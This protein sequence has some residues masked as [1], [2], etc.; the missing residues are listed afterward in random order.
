M[1]PS[2][3]EIRAITP[4]YLVAT[5][6]AAFAGRGQ[7]DFLGS[8][9]LED[10]IQLTDGREELVGDVASA[11]QDVRGFVADE[12]EAL[13]EQPRFVDAVFGSLRGDAASQARAED[14]VLP[15]LRALTRS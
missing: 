6:L 5:K 7:G 1:L 12:I 2:G 10:I 3:A 13:L 4:P 15:R 11:D 8:R 14:V 9:D